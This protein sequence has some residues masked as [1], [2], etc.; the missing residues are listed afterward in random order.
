MG[1]AGWH[2]REREVGGQTAGSVA[3]SEEKIVVEE[4]EAEV[5]FVVLVL[6]EEERS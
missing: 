4:K 2:G 3:Y 5:E 1:H 6:K